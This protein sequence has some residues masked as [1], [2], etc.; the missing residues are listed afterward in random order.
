MDTLKPWVA[1]LDEDVDD[2]IFW[3]HGFRRWAQHLDLYWFSSV[4]EFLSATSLGH[5][6]PVAL[7][8]DGVVPDGEEMKW[9]STLL[10][11]PS[12]Q[13]ACLIMLSAEVTQ[14]QREAYLRLGASDHLQ[15][16]VR[17]QELQE[18]VSTVSTHIARKSELSG[19]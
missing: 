6:K 2:Y 19:L 5:D 9:L 8:M 3:Q 13:Q 17:L 11:H 16:P 1:L 12:C 15:K 14:P 7:V 4:T 18:I 10:L